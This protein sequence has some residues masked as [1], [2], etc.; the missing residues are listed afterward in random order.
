MLTKM[1]HGDGYLISTIFL[2]RGT[3]VE[4]CHA[5]F[6]TDGVSSES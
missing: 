1:N 3:P 6:V 5:R 2:L 4:Q